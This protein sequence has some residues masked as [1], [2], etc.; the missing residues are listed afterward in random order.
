VRREDVSRQG[1]NGTVTFA[2]TFGPE[3]DESGDPV[4]DAD[5]Q[6]VI[7]PVTSIERYRRTV[8]FQDLGMSPETIRALGGGASQ[9]QVTGGDPEAGIRQWDLGLFAQDEWRARPDLTLG[10]G[11]RYEN[12]TNVS[13]DL[14]FSPRVYFAWSPGR[15]EG[16]TP[17]T[18]V[19][20]GLGVFHSRVSENL[21]LEA[22][23]FDGTEPRRYLVTDPEI[24]DQAWYGLDGS[25]SGL[26]SFEELGQYAQPEV[27]RV[28]APD[29]RTPRTLQASL[30]V[31]RVLPRGMTGS[32]TW[33][34]SRTT[35]ALRSVVV[36]LPA[37]DTEP[38]EPTVAYQYESTGRATQNRLMFGL[39]RRPTGGLGFT[40][41]YFLS[42][43]RSD[44]DGA[45]AF[46]AD[47]GD[48]G[49]EWGRSSRD[50]RHRLV[51]MGHATLPGDVRL[52]PFLL[53]SSGS[54]FNITIGRDWNGDTVFTDRP[55]YA[56][57]P[58]A[59]DVVETEWGLFDPTP[60]PGVA[61]IPRNL[62]EGPS[63]FA[64]NLRLSKTIR[65][66][67]SPEPRDPEP[68]DRPPGGRPPGGGFGPGG[69]GGGRGGGP[70]GGLRGGP[71]GGGSGP[72]LTI[73]V[74]AQNLFD[75]VNPGPP[76]GN[77]SSPSFGES[78][79]SAGGFGRG[80]GRM[81]AGNRTVELQLRLSF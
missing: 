44:T 9:Y 40:A 21:I 52:S 77:L 62:G 27:T 13:S 69:R 49:A 50:V 16:G 38:G 65:L 60:A 61:L 6:P 30:G 28:L 56:T 37:A 45:G 68:G 75:R 43:S 22:H 35:R 23:R 29:L 19:R 51:L 15:R 14:D 31:E 48:L 36:A 41:R 73:A 12:Q 32:L 7:V 59:P 46:P 4:L 17:G 55:A 26:P 47:S 58:T 39:T 5:G 74:Y 64:F 80:R 3:L 10:L 78:L 33:T 20:G 54:P 2:G 53:Y 24:L 42:W 70:G 72:G 79:S 63:F 25:V 8:L 18:V 1:F 76:V 57:D 81:T 66:R 11:L 71:S 67:S 34:G